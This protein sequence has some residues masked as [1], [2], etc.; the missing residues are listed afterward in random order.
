MADRGRRHFTC[1]EVTSLQESARGDREWV[2]GPDCPAV[3]PPDPER[4]RRV[5]AR[6]AADARRAGFA[7]DLLLAGGRDL[8][9][10]AYRRGWTDGYVA[11]LTGNE[12]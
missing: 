5:A 9:D 11:A 12:E 6:R 10:D 1:I 4:D 7:L 8:L 3:I 2:C